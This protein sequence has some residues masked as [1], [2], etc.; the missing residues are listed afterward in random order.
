[1]TSPQSAAINRLLSQPSRTYTCAALSLVHAVVH[2]PTAADAAC[3]Y[4][5]AALRRGDL[6]ERDWPE[7]DAMP[8]TV[9]GP[10]RARETV[11]LMLDWEPVFFDAG[12]PINTNHGAH[13]G[14]AQG[15]EKIC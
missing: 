4:L 2:A 8:V 9:V 15:I 13:H 7:V 6:D 1:M 10:D 12:P 14:G 5:T 3:K 11:W